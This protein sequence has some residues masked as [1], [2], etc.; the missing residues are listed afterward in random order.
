MDKAVSVV[1]DALGDLVL[2]VTKKHCTHGC[3]WVCS[4]VACCKLALVLG[5]PVSCFCV[6]VKTKTIIDISELRIGRH[7]SPGDARLSMFPVF[8]LGGG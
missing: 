7:R 6:T 4:A 5:C 1:M 3:V 2:K 8:Q